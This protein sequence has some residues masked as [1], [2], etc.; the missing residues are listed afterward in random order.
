M[1]L[2]RF[3]VD[4]LATILNYLV[5][6]WGNHMINDRLISF[7]YLWFCGVAS[8]KRRIIS[9]ESIIKGRREDL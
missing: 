6:L 7:F 5:C 1:A 9:S 3:Q 8:S 4:L 2:A